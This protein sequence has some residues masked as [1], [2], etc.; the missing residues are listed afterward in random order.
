MSETAVPGVGVTVQIGVQLIHNG[1]APVQAMEITTDG[2]AVDLSQTARLSPDVE[3]IRILYTAIHLSAP[4]QV[5]YSY[6]LSG[7]E[8]RWVSAGARR[9][10]LYNTPKH[11]HYRFTVRAQLPDG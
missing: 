8:S 3:R 9:E 6:Q 4:E 7:L 2:R 5:A 10:R 11:G 1:P